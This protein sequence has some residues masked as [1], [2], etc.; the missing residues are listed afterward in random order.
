MAAGV[1]WE[2]EFFTDLKKD[3]QPLCINKHCFSGENSV[4]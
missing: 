2:K 4:C 1:G 3:S